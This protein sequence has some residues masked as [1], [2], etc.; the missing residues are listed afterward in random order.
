MQISKTAEGGTVT[1]D[2]DDFASGLIPQGASSTNT[3]PLKYTGINGFSTAYNI[4][5]DITNGCLNQALGPAAN[6]TNFASLGGALVSANA[7]SSGLFFTLDSSGKVHKITQTGDALTLD[8]TSPFP[9]TIAF[10]AGSTYVGQDTILY[11]HNLSSAST[12]SFFYSA[13]NSN[14]WD[15]GAF[16]TP[17]TAVGDFN[18]DFMSTIPATPLDITTGDGDS[19]SQ[20]NLPHPME[21]GADAIL[22]IGSG[23]Y[24]HAYDGNTGA[25]GT[26]YSKVLTL[27][28]GSIVVGMRKFKSSLLIAT[29]FD[30]NFIA[31]YSNG[32]NSSAAFVYEWNYLDLD[33]T[34]V[35]DTEEVKISAITVWKGS[36]VFVASGVYESN[37]NNKLKVIE[38]NTVRTIASF[39]G[40]LP[41]NR[42][43]ITSSTAFYM[44]CPEG[45]YRVGSKFKVGNMISK[46]GYL[47]S[48]YSTTPGMFFLNADRMIASAAKTTNYYLG[49]GASTAGT[50][51]AAYCK[52]PNLGNLFPSGKKGR[53]KYLEVEY[54]APITGAGGLTA[55]ISTDTNTV[56]TTVLNAVTTVS[57]NLL[58]RYTR[59]SSNNILPTFSNFDLS[60]EWAA[61]TGPK[62]ARMMVEYEL[63]EITN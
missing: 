24:I 1:W 56:V 30:P 63:L 44:N 17:F 13:Y 62:I 45:L 60:V 41:T 21:I 11:R 52:F 20:K 14:N 55:K 32:D 10:A 57:G 29:N 47:G 3:Y 28:E 39:D 42:G 53:I 36:P 48:T 27:P 33:T 61:G 26:F 15:V 6:V 58:K 12:V 37:G 5:Q 51:I 54:Q 34:S 7:L 25:N 43:V 4:D 49:V 19:A 38:G 2:S 9:H 31:G 59:D 23:R 46:Y 22:Y 50:G 40:G 16:T 18:D 35:I 8:T